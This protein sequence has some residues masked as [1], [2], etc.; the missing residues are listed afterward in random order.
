MQ[1]GG[2]DA[3]HWWYNYF[4]I[5]RYAVCVFSTVVAG[6]QGNGVSANIRIGMLHNLPSASCPIAKVPVVL[7]G[8][9]TSSNRS[10][11]R[12][13]VILPSNHRIS[14]K[15]RVRNRRNGTHPIV[16]QAR[17]WID[18]VSKCHCGCICSASGGRGPISSS[19]AVVEIRVTGTTQAN[20]HCGWSS[21]VNRREWS[22]HKLDLLGSFVKFYL[23][24]KI[25]P[26]I[27]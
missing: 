4:H 7:Y 18:Q 11:K 21:I 13:R 8:R 24:V 5:T 12:D 17:W 15:V 20:L 16:S 19:G 23:E 22:I 25:I 14:G 2:V 26:C 6:G 3:D 9:R 10:G 1:A 27:V